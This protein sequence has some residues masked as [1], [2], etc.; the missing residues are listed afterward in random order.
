LH[1]SLIHI[2]HLLSTQKEKQIHYTKVINVA[3]EPYLL[4][5]FFS[6][7]ATVPQLAI[8]NVHFMSNYFADSLKFLHLKNN[9]TST[10]VY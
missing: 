10:N 1:Q 8:Y 3:A 5:V 2:N 7:R 9:I 4:T 6:F